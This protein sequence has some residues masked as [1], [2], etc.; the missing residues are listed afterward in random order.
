MGDHDDRAAVVV[1][2]AAQE[3]EDRAP[4]A[5]IERAGRLVGEDDLRPRDQRAGDRDSLLL[6]AGELCRT[7]AQPIAQPDPGR[8]IA[9]LRPRR[10]APIESERQADVLRD[11]Q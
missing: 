8:S 2:E 10:P 1:D 3:L 7:V 5:G 4:V 6:A 9:H 11:R